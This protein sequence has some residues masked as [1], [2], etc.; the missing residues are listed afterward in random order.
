MHSAERCTNYN[1]LIYLEIALVLIL[2]ARW[3][4]SWRSQV[5]PTSVPNFAPFP[6]CDCAQNLMGNS[7]DQKKYSKI[8]SRLGVSG[9]RYSRRKVEPT[10][11]SLSPASLA[12][13]NSDVGPSRK[14]HLKFY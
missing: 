2:A 13:S 14:L 12:Q 8:S 4:F 5:A 9:Q 10:N 11:S 1:T 7:L 3:W 6:W